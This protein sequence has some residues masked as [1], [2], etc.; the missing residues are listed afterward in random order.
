MLRLTHA[1][2]WL[3]AA[4]RWIA[5]RSYALY[6]MHLTILTDVIERPVL[7]TGLLPASVCAMLAILLP[8]ALAELSYR[9]LEAPVLRWR[10]DQRRAACGSAG[11]AVIAAVGG[12]PV[13]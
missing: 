4:V 5:A 7:E 1:A 13:A 10:P 3:E 6:L 8:F 9:F 12:L 11:L 2:G